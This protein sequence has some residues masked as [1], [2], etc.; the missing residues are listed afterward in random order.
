MFSA[1]KWKTT[2]LSW[3]HRVLD[4]SI[5]YILWVIGFMVGFPGFHRLY[6]RKYNTGTALRF[7]PGLGH[8][9]AFFDLFA[10][11]SQ[12]RE[13][14]LRAKYRSVLSRRGDAAL[15]QYR[16]DHHPAKKNRGIITPGEVALEG[17]I[18]I[19]EAKKNLDDLASKGFTEL[20]VKQSGVVV[21][22]FPE[23]MDHGE[24]E[25]LLDV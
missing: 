19:Q 25:K 14:N 3:E 2:F 22:T 7:I 21:Y 18:S 20:R 9:I 13:I 16:D 5:A 10:I 1:V 11:P 24:D 23:F 12:I 8:M 15:D 4:S 6:M 17:N